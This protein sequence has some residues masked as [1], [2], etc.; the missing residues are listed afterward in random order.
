MVMQ[1][2]AVPPPASAQLVPIEH[3]PTLSMTRM[4]SSDPSPAPAE[5]HRWDEGLPF[6]LGSS[7]PGV[8]DL[9]QRL[10][11]IGYWIGDDRLGEFERGTADA[12]LSFQR[13]RGLRPDGKCGTHTWSSLV[14]AGF[15]LGDR[16]LY[17]RSPMLH[18]DDVAD[19]QRRLSALG[20][21][22]GGVDAIF[23]DQTATALAEFQHNMGIASDG[24]CGPRSLAELN[25]L[26][27]RKGGEDL[28]TNI[29]EGL[30]VGASGLELRTI[31]VGE[32]GGFQSG[33]AAVSR[34][35]AG[36]GAVPLSI[37][38][39]DDA[40]QA[41]ASNSAGADC[42]VGLRIDPER[43]GVRTIYYRGFRYESEMSKQL[44]SIVTT[45]LAEVLEL[46]DEG[47][48]GMA[49]PVLRQTRMPAVVIELG[50]PA[51]VAMRTAEL[52]S[53]IVW[54]LEHWL[55]EAKN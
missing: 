21:D 51:T 54:A 34:A 24:I 5:T 22:S 6:G 3:D 36:A 20:F 15:R 43:S 26:S 9:Q 50:R 4:P 1:L 10:A 18:G 29:R 23:G 46:P 38:H 13:D 49:L 16:L 41:D 8:S 32:T 47:T 35:L 12:I 7:G 19:L 14:E 11:R 33:V 2:A 27:L 37:H 52:A 31:A 45:R 42:Y 53:S 40:E 39:P 30:R 28:V 25:R 17:R 55:S 44:A 48:A